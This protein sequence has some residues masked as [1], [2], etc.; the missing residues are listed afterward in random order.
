M[1]KKFQKEDSETFKKKHYFEYYTPKEPKSAYNDRFKTQQINNL[2]LKKFKS[3]TKEEEPSSAHLKM[4]KYESSY[5]PNQ[6]K[7]ASITRK[8]SDFSSS[9]S[10]TGSKMEIHDFVLGKTLGQGKFGVVYQATHK[11]S[12]WLVALKKVPK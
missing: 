10:I 7:S 1:Q 12:G 4:K 9:S 5:L 8:I 2:D 6:P 3:Y 11:N